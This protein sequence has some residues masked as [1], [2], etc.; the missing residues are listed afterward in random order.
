MSP[1]GSEG[2]AGKRCSWAD[3]SAAMRRY[4]DEEWGVP[5]R[6]DVHLFEMLVL[7]GAQ[8]GLSWSTILNKRDAH[9]RASDDFDPVR[10]AGYGERKIASLLQNS[11]IVRNRL[12][13]RSAV[14]NA[15]AFLTIREEHGSFADYLWAF[16]D[17]HPVINHP[18][19]LEE[20]PARTE[21]SDRVSQDLKRNG[22]TFV[23]STIVYA[24]LQGVGVVDDHVVGCPAK[25]ANGARKPRRR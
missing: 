4:H 8:A 5:S 1:P 14:T 13:V 10:I 6:D 20:L 18:R 17:G 2:G 7:E 21:L 25:R 11:G 3:S 15:Q 16:V 22:F 24:Y 9:R 19:S 12:K 23:G